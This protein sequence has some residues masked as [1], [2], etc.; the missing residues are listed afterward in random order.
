MVPSP[1]PATAGF[2]NSIRAMGRPLTNCLWAGQTH[3]LM[4]CNINGL[5][6]S[7]CQ[8]DWASCQMRADGLR[9]DLRHSNGIG[10]LTSQKQTSGKFKLST[11]TEQALYGHV[12]GK[13][14]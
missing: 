1:G 14:S 6:G 10:E 3:N 7:S 2:F 5:A 9:D 13:H 12:R 4:Y 8:G 11:S